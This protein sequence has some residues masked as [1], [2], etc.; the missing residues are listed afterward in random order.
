MRTPWIRIAAI[1]SISL[2]L[3]LGGCA[4][5]KEDIFPKDMR[6]M[7]EV[8]DD[9]FAKLRTREIEGARVRVHGRFRLDHLG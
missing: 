2:V 9:H 4:S 1:T 8:Y 5:T 7:G 6:P 3:V